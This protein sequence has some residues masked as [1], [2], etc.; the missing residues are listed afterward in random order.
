MPRK[1]R[2]EG[3]ESHGLVPVLPEEIQDAAIRCRYGG[4]ALPFEPVLRTEGLARGI[5]VV[6]SGCRYAL[7]VVAEAYPVWLVPSPDTPIERFSGG[8]AGREADLDQFSGLEHTS[9]GP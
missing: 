8:P 4:S 3:V 7:G 6:R 9:R 5:Q 2:Q 1:G